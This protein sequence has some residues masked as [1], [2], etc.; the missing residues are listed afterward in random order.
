MS[1]IF[2]DLTGDSDYGDNVKFEGSFY[3]NFNA[4]FLDCAE[5]TIGDG[6]LFGPK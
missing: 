5:I 2:W 1:S 3:C 6:V 4:T